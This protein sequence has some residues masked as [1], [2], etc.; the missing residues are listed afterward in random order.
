M[1]PTDTFDV[2]KEWKKQHNKDGVEV[3]IHNVLANRFPI[4]NKILE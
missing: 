2:Y 4:R 1:V 3:K